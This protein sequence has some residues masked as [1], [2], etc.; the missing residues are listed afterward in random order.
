MK[1]KCSKCFDKKLRHGI[2]WCLLFG[3]IV[4]F[5]VFMFV[6]DW[7]FMLFALGSLSL[8][9]AVTALGFWLTDGD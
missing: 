3:P 4:A 7:K 8:F 6:V 5:V 2:G 9:S 1:S